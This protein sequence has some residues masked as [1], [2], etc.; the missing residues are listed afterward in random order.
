M[1]R[2]WRSNALLPALSLL[3][4]A[5]YSVGRATG[6]N[7]GL[8]SVETVDILRIADHKVAE[9]RRVGGGPIRS[10]PPDASGPGAIASGGQQPAGTPASGR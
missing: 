1:H 5:V 8:D 7:G 4:V 6:P 3:S 2:Q 10:L 9:H